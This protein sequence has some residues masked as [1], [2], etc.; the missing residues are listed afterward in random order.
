MGDSHC[1]FLVVEDD[2]AVG[3]ALSRIVRSYGEVALATTAS[4]A[5]RLLEDAGPWQAFLLDVGLPDGSGLDL[6]ADVRG[7]FPRP[8]RSC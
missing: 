1:R 2:A 8:R 6:L 5:R 7:A 3:R 4:D